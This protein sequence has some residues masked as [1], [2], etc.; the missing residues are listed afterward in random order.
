[1]KRLRSASR[2]CRTMFCRPPARAESNRFSTRPS[3]TIRMSVGCIWRNPA[4]RRAESEC[5]TTRPY[6]PTESFRTAGGK[7]C[8]GRRRRR[9]GAGGLRQY[10]YLA[11]QFAPE[12]LCT[13]R[14]EL[15]VCDATGRARSMDVALGAVAF[16]LVEVTGD[17]ARLV[18]ESGRP[19]EQEFAILQ[20]LSGHTRLVITLTFP[21]LRGMPVVVGP[22]L[23]AL[24]GNGRLIRRE[25]GLPPDTPA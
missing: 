19:G 16:H 4:G 9:P 24:C 13:S 22:H 5:S 21:G 11:G 7:C 17:E 2:R 1:M 18:W 8:S 25:Q 14:N 3:V 15:Y 20:W 6:V 12:L 23:L 10:C